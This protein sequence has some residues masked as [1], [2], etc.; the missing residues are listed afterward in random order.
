M[1]W[2]KY[3]RFIPLLALLVY[4]FFPVSNVWGQ[5]SI[6]TV[7]LPILIF[8]LVIGVGLLY[9]K[10]S[11]KNVDMLKQEL[12][13]AGWQVSN[14][15]I[16]LMDA[17]LHLLSGGFGGGHEHRIDLAMS[18]D[19]N[20]CAITILA[21]NIIIRSNRSSRI[22]PLTV[23]LSQLPGKVNGWGRIR[24]ANTIFAGFDRDV[25]LESVEFNKHVEVRA[26]PKEL[27]YAL[28]P[29]EVMSH[30]LDLL[31]KPWFHIEGGWLATVQEKQVV[32]AAELSAL[33]NEH[34][35]MYKE[36]LDEGVFVKN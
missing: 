11:R 28:F 22:I 25:D 34:R 9:P 26:N 13:T 15:P 30:Y 17:V 19:V 32:D 31:E 2:K 3:I 6:M 20:G 33:V 10:Y 35:F 14:L 16:P 18:K 36:L 12:L 23:A 21:L 5:S 27:A 24:D 1:N 8:G 4:Y 29:P 7:V